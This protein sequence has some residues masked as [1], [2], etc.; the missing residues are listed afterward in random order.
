MA[1]PPAVAAS[2]DLGGAAPFRLALALLAAACAVAQTTS[3]WHAVEFHAVAARERRSRLRWRR[4]VVGESS[5]SR[6]RH[7]LTPRLASPRRLPRRRAVPGA[8]QHVTLAPL[9][10]S[11][12]QVDW[13]P[14]LSDGGR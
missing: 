8:P 14:P 4:G 12:L 7:C 5:T 10:G 13:T 11:S 6:A 9:S 3:A 1:A 2:R